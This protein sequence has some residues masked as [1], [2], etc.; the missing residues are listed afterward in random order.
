ML[1]NAQGKY[2]GA[3]SSSNT[4]TLSTNKLVHTIS[5]SSDG[6]TLKSEF[7]NM[8]RYNESANRFRYYK[9]GQKP[10]QLYKKVEVAVVLLGDVDG[11]G[12]ISISDV[13]ALVNIILGRD[14]ADYNHEAADVDGD[15]DVSISDV[16]ALV[17]IILNR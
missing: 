11:D 1:Y 9:S 17:N 7:G 6:V 13:T 12:S 8:L 14:N 4:L 2:L 5:L 16:T 15:G 3:S 10:I